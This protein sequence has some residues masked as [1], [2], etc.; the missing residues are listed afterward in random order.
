MKINQKA[1]QLI[2]E[3]KGFSSLSEQELKRYKDS[4]LTLFYTVQSI[5]IIVFLISLILI[6]LS[7]LA[8]VNTEI[9][10]LGFFAGAFY[11][12]GGTFMLLTI[13]YTSKKPEKRLTRLY[14]K[15]IEREKKIM[16]RI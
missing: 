1:K 2:L 13:R 10:Q 8:L 15:Q 6:L 4:D 11:G 5:N 12:I 16:K 3:G 7:I 14:D 9:T